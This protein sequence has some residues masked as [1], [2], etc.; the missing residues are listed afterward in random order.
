MVKGPV[1]SFGN[2]ELKLDA[3]PGQAQVL[4]TDIFKAKGLEI[5]SKSLAVNTTTSGIMDITLNEAANYIVPAGSYSV[6]TGRSCSGSKC[7]FST[8]IY[9]QKERKFG[10]YWLLQ[11]ATWLLVDISL[12]EATGIDVDNKQ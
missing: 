6:A 7:N 1:S 3:T 4:K 10:E 9:S 8:T 12:L 5:D 11:D 2:Y